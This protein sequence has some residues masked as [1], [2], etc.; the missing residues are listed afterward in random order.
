[1]RG[2]SHH[3]LGLNPA[4]SLLGLSQSQWVTPAQPFYKGILRLEEQEK[5]ILVELLQPT[6]R[7]QRPSF[8]V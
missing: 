4:K 7:A 6:P 5:G 2:W 1:L 3:H 8:K